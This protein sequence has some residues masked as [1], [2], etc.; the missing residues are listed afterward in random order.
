MGGRGWGEGGGGRGC[1]GGEGGGG[2]RLQRERAHERVESF[3]I[4]WTAARVDKGG[5]AKALG[6]GGQLRAGGVVRVVVALVV[7]EGVVAPGGVGSAWGG[8]G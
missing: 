5:D 2:V 6:G 3:G 1:G 8:E 7:A 4:E